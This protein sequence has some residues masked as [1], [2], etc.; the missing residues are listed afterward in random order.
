VLSNGSALAPA[1]V[2]TIPVPG[3]KN[4]ET[5]THD[6]K[7]LLVAGNSGAAVISV[8]AAETGSGGAVVGYLTAASGTGAN[9]IAISPDDQ[10]AFV[11][12]QTSRNIGV[13]RLG[14]ALAHGFGPANIVGYVPVGL[15]PYSITASPEGDWLYVASVRSSTNFTNPGQGTITVISEPGAESDPAKAVVSHA[16]AGCSPVRVITSAD[17]STV[18][19]AA[20]QSDSVLAFSAARLRTDPAHSLLAKVGV[21]ADPVGM[22]LYAS[23]SRLAVADSNIDNVKGAMPNLAIISTTAALSGKP[24]L[25]GLI[26]SGLLPRQVL[27]LPGGQVLL[28]TTTTSQELQAIKIAD[29]P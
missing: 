26:K 17:G 21:G 22:A 7:Y 4:G 3:A 24:S 15:L 27:T 28:V 10:F 11:S 29:L 12:F 25:L 2:R 20:R 18:W 9:Q 1:L 14:D 6:G 5:L 8:A 19:V 16:E 13:F 23:G